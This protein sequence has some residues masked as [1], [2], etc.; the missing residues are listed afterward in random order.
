M[1]SLSQKT[2]LIY[3]PY[4]LSCIPCPLT[5]FKFLNRLGKQ[6]K[7][8]LE[9]Q[10]LSADPKFAIYKVNPGKLLNLSEDQEDKST[11]TKQGN[12]N[13]SNGNISSFFDF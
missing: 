6:E 5:T 10:N 9:N 12:M 1:N 4:I 13:F 11:G 3:L 8:G 2:H 7:H